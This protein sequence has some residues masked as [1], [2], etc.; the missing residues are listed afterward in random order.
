VGE[1]EDSGAFDGSDA[2]GA[3]VGE[4]LEGVALFLGEAYR[5]RFFRHFIAYS[6]IRRCTK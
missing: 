6:L 1:E 2:V 4:G 5:V 3:F